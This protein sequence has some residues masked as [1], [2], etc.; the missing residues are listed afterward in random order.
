MGILSWSSSRK[1]LRLMRLYILTPCQL[2]FIVLR[3]FLLRVGRRIPVRWHELDLPAQ[4]NEKQ[5]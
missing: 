1:Y 4:Q 3:H 5:K 2:T